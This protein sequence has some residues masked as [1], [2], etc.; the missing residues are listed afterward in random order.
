MRNYL[1]DRKNVVPEF[2]SLKQFMRYCREYEN[3]EKMKQQYNTYATEDQRRTRHTTSSQTQN[4]PH[5]STTKRG[6]GSHSHS[7]TS[8]R[9]HTSSHHHQSNHQTRPR[10]HR[11]DTKNGLRPH[12]SGKDV[13]LAK[14]SKS[15]LHNSSR[16]NFPNKNEVTRNANPSDLCYDCKKP[17][18]FAKDCPEPRREGLHAIYDDMGE[19]VEQVGSETLNALVEQEESYS[20][21]ESHSEVTGSPDTLSGE[22]RSLVDESDYDSCSCESGERLAVMQSCEIDT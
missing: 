6:S 19:V 5:S 11:T 22:I 21:S 2:V 15:H 13:K 14:P 4:R 20:N 18:H 3:K 9:P 12:M 16:G 17:G 1:I 10:D 7:H 8:S